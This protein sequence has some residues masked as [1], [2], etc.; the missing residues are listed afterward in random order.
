MKWFKHMTRSLTDAKIEILIM[1]F[2]IEAY[3]VYFGVLEIIAGNL[4][5]DNVTFE[6]EH[7]IELLAHKWKIDTIRLGHIIQE[8]FNLELLELCE[9]GH[10]ACYKLV[11]Y[12]DDTLS[13]NQEI[14]NMAKNPKYLEAKGKIGI[15]IDDGDNGDPGITP[16][17]SEELRVT[18]NVSDQTKLNKIKL[19]K[20]N[21]NSLSPDEFQNSEEREPNS[22]FHGFI[23]AEK[24]HKTESLQLYKKMC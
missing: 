2:G 4:T 11:K 21:K 9:S 19:N 1:K 23:P 20:I 10:W 3:G 5:S 6:I 15:L 12:V 18:P 22:N 7:N 13:K 16:S 14:K 24:V 17:N 8:C